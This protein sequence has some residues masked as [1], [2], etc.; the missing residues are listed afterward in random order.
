MQAVKHIR[1][2]PD[3]DR[4]DALEGRRFVSNIEIM[5]MRALLAPGLLVLALGASVA[6]EPDG[7]AEPNKPDAGAP[8]VVV[9]NGSATPAEAHGESTGHP[10]PRALD[11]KRTP[12]PDRLAN[13]HWMQYYPMAPPTPPVPEGTGKSGGGASRVNT[14]YKGAT[15][16]ATGGAPPDLPPDNVTHTPE[17]QMGPTVPSSAP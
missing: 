15:K 7:T 2:F 13:D 16:G 6:A 9:P 3:P 11:S 4:A 17:D 1:T 10:P 12:M 14:I 5:G 8:L